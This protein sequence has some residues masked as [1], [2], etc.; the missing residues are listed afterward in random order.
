MMSGTSGDCEV[1][2]HVSFQIDLCPGVVLPE[3]AWIS[4]YHPEAVPQDE[5]KMNRFRTGD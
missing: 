3:G 4:K 5:G 1:C 2:C